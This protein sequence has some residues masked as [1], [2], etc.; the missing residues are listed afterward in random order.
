MRVRRAQPGFRKVTPG[1]PELRQMGWSETSDCTDLETCERPTAWGTQSR[2]DDRSSMS[3]RWMSVRVAGLIKSNVRVEDKGPILFF[4][5][6]T[7][8]LQQCGIEK[9]DEMDEPR[10]TALPV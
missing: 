4:S 6:S 1:E 3:R 5:G 10:N 9:S 8:S 2:D 7:E